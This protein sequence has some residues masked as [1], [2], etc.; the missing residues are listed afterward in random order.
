[1]A[2]SGFGNSYNN[3]V[4]SQGISAL[5]VV[6][7]TINIPHTFTVGSPQPIQSISRG[8][9]PGMINVGTWTY[10]LKNFPANDLPSGGN[11]DPFRISPS[12]MLMVKID[13]PSFGGGRISWEWHNPS[14]TIV[15][16]GYY[17][18]GGGSIW[19]YSFIGHFAWEIVN[20][21]TYYVII[22]TP[23]GSARLDFTII[24]TNP[25]P[26]GYEAPWTIVLGESIV[27]T[28]HPFVVT[29][30]F[31]N[32]FNA[33]RTN[34]FRDSPVYICTTFK[35]MF[36]GHNVNIK[37]TNVDTQ[38]IVLNRNFTYVAPPLPVGTYYPLVFYIHNI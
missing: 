26:I 30:R 7:D 33:D 4:M 3:S 1:M 34:P 29:S 22:T 14:G 36:Y 19:A 16:S 11:T 12:E 13:I 5:N 10:D 23:N 24:N 17:D 18:S 6:S 2:G 35:N 38:V 25:L 21:G 20:T 15:Y 28:S 32:D 8:T 37:I 27:A 31:N 9:L